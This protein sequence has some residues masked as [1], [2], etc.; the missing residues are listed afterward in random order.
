M[1]A[2]MRWEKLIVMGASL[3]ALGLGGMSAWSD[4]PAG[5]GQARE[6]Y[7]PVPMPPGF[8][9]EATELEGPVFADARG[10][11]LYVW[12]QHELRDGYVGDPKGASLCTSIKETTTDGLMDPYPAGLI[13]PDLATRPSCTQEWPIVRAEK[14]AKPVGDWTIIKR[15]DG[16]EQWAYKDEA[17]Y[18]SVLDRE[19]GDTYGGTRRREAGDGPAVRQPVGAPDDV[20]PGLTVATT[21]LGRP[22]VTA[23]GKFSSVYIYDKDGRDHSNCDSA[24]L[25]T[26]K[27]V[28]APELTARSHGAWSV[29]ERTPGTRQWAFQGKPLYTY[30]LGQKPRGQEGSDVPGWHDVYLQRA[31]SPPSEF[32]VQDTTSG[33]VLADAQ[34]KTIYV[35]RCGDDAFDQLSCDDPDDTQA[36]R[37]AMC[38]GGSVELCLKNFPYVLAPANARSKSSTWTVME[39]DPK[40]G[41]RAAKGQSD[42]L[43]VWA[44]RDR[45]VYTYAGDEAPGEYY[46]ES[47]GEY[48]GKRDGFNAFWLRDDFFGEDD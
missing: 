15:K 25:E 17:L 14:G 29:F 1:G 46:A 33:E 8:R 26:W 43:R 48:Y 16:I 13:L 23:D 45:P 47:N 11:T 36:Y 7:R 30:S 27:P 3:A 35:Y 44:Y 9:V 2:S 37:Q 34:G 21:A 10:K 12:P 38:G 6:A 40:S 5:A 18:T 24:C 19:P 39:I 42:A 20:P 32:T 22:L 28:L 31:P 41:H 4:V